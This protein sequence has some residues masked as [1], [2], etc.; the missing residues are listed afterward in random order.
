M[1]GLRYHA[2]DLGLVGD[3]HVARYRE[4]GGEV[5]YVWNG[6]STLLLTTV[7]RRTRRPRTSALIFGRDGD[8]YVVVASMGGAPKHPQ[9]YLN[10]GADPVAEVQVRTQTERVR[11]RTAAGDERARLWTLMTR[12]WPNYDVYQART[13]RRIPVVVLSPI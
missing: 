9:W 11:A 12:V 1:D 2:P 6:V 5:G 3:E 13:E 4:T 10:L 7:G 8:D